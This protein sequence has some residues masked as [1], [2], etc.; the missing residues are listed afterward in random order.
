MNK[1]WYRAIL[2]TTL[3]IGV[4]CVVFGV[5]W[6][7]ILSNQ[8]NRNVAYQIRSQNQQIDPQSQTEAMGLISAGE[9]LRDLDHNR[10]IATI[11]GGAGLILVAVAWLSR[12][13]VKSRQ[14]THQAAEAGR[15]DNANR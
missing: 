1:D 10:N 5:V 7:A 12:D 11:V 15:A 3:I 6:Y 13:F 14:R 9:A 4:L 8:M 2:L